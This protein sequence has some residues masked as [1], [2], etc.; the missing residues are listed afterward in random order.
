[1]I[2]PVIFA[3]R[4]IPGQHNL[5]AKLDTLDALITDEDLATYGAN[6]CLLSPSFHKRSY[7]FRVKCKGKSWL[8]HITNQGHLVVRVDS[9]AD[10]PYGGH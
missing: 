6:I 2:Q 9:K 5:F 7:T 3:A 4:D 1:M 10:L 8:G